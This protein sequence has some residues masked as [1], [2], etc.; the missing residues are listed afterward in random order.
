MSIRDILTDS[1]KLFDKIEHHWKMGKKELKKG[2]AFGEVHTVMGQ[3]II[4]KG[5]ICSIGDMCE[6]GNE[7]IKCEVI[8]VQKENVYL[9][10]YDKG[11]TFRNG[12]KVKILERHRITLP[13]TKQLLGKVF[14]GFGECYD[15]DFESQRNLEKEKVV[16][17][18]RKPPNALKRKRIDRV[19]PTGVRSIDGLLTI[20]EGQRM[21]V[22]AGTGVGKSTLLSMIAKKAHSDVNVIALIGERG[23]EVLEFIEDSLGEEGMSKSVLIVA[24][25]DEGDMVKIKAAQLAM[26]IAEMFRDEGKKVMFMLD[27]ITRFSKAI[28]NVDMA[29]GE[30]LMGEK[31]PSMEPMMQQIL[32]RAG[33]GENG[34]ITMIA[35]VL[36]NSD[37]MNGAIADIARGIL[38]GHIILDRKL[39]NINHFPAIN[40]LASKSRLMDI[41][42]DE[43]HKEIS[44]KM[45]KYMGIYEENKDIIEFGDYKRSSN[46]EIIKAVH[47]YPQIQ[48]FLKQKRDEY[49]DFEDVLN[50]IEK[51]T[52]V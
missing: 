34:S 39:A 13:D 17:L 3:A 50:H 10:P 37:D 4:S 29:T 45:I 44:D 38:D 48:E 28:Q 43:R 26:S 20:G 19:I 35:T 16:D 42:V 52:N 11:H 21:G 15:E 33:M 8:S 5:P 31:T 14:N 36:V 6:V 46:K 23:R 7:R 49:V 9:I 51:I 24:T 32:E 40:V 18:Y 47:L 25:S 2:I 22:F 12:Q 30:L 1:T 27:A 41:I